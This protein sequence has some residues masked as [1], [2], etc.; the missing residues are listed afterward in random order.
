MSKLNL[1]VCYASGDRDNKE[2]LKDYIKDFKSRK[3]IANS[4]ELELTH[5][6]EDDIKTRIQAANVIVLIIG[7]HFLES[8][9]CES[10]RQSALKLKGNKRENVAHIM[11]NPHVYHDGDVTIL[12]DAKYPISNTDHW[13]SEVNAWDTTAAGLEAILKRENV[14]SFWER[15]MGFLQKGFKPIAAV[16][17][18]LLLIALLIKGIMWFLGRGTQARIACEKDLWAEKTVKEAIHFEVFEGN[19]QSKG[20]YVNALTDYFV[21]YKIDCS[22]WKVYNQSSE[23]PD[24]AFVNFGLQG[25]FGKSF[26]CI[27]RNVTAKKASLVVIH[28]D[29]KGN[30]LLEQADIGGQASCD[31]CLSIE[32]LPAGTALGCAK[33][34]VSNSDALLLKRDKTA[35][36]VLWVNNEGKIGWCDQAK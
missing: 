3:L 23:K 34:Q 17:M 36:Q 22:R 12:P 16:A 35:N 32:V 33:K 13:R 2:M 30:P 29:S 15:M 6:N 8:R 7:E 26:A 24:W 28:F 27:V 1:L 11:L 20:V 31:D 25:K 14:P 19:E 10:I 18:G 21:K 4:E 9:K 5:H